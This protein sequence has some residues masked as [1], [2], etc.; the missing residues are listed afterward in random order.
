MALA[1][2]SMPAQ[3]KKNTTRRKATATSVATGKARK[4]ATAASKNKAKAPSKAPQK[5]TAKG[6]RGLKKT[7]VASDYSNATIRGLRTQRADIQRKIKIQEQLLKKNKAD[8]MQRLSHLMAINSEID[9]REKSINGIQKDI[10][11]I[12]GNIGMLKNQLSQ[13]ELQLQD[14]KAKYVKSMRYMATNRTV[15]DKLMFVF[16]AKNLAQMY[17]RMRFVREYA[18]YQRAQGEMVKAKQDQI[19]S[20]HKQL[21]VVRGQKNTLLYKGKQEQSVLQGKQAEQQEMVN[22]LQKQQKTIQLIIDEQR[23]KN[24]ALNARIDQLVAQEVAKAK[25]RAEAEARRKAAAAAA[26]AKKKAEELAR[27][28]A[29]A[30]AAAREN[31]RRV[32]EAK[33][34]ERQL[35][36]EAEAAAQRSAAEKAKAEQAAKEAESNRV[37]AERKARV[38]AERHKKEVA[39]AKKEVTEAATMDSQDKQLSGS[40]ERNRGRL[41]MPITG[42]YR[43]VSHYGQ[44]KVEGLK[45]V[46]LDNKGINIL[47]GAGACARSIYDGE[48]SAVFGFGDT[49]VV[50][51]R[52]GSYIS[53]YCNLRSVSVH[54]GQHVSTRQV[55]GTVGTDNILQFQLRHGTAKLNPEAWLGR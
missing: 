25:A 18:D 52:H 26:A 36:A 12:E 27:K 2:L 13:L 42:S 16:S 29:A 55:L 5:T 4:H 35:K 41:P 44:Y 32:A 50:M 31:A 8:V 24:A 34:R 48:V 21:E 30:E 10:H 53:V 46:R 54:R 1:V 39:E 37:A 47:G 3:N 28:K 51:V 22:S 6:K 45:N 11:H 20:K 14:R 17:R 38:E 49:M 19:T 7:A 9:Q 43:I 15:Q 33:E 40:F 23:K